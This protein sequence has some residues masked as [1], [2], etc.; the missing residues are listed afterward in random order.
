MTSPGQTRPD[1]D[2]L[3]SDPQL[4][5]MKV[6]EGR[7]SD[8]AAVAAAVAAAAE[9]DVDAAAAAAEDEDSASDSDMEMDTAAVSSER[10][11]GKGSSNP[12]LQ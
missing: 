9:A 7:D 2:T 4:A 12:R 3:P 11:T 1:R 8:E 10:M 6:E 5:V